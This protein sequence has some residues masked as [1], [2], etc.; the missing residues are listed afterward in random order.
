M[1]D[2]AFIT[3]AVCYLVNQLIISKLSY[4]LKQRDEVIDKANELVIRIL[5]GDK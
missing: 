4:Q 5:K 1:G 3:L 2:I